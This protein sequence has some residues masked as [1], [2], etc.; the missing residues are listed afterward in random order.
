MSTT[1]ATF[2]GA[3][4]DREALAIGPRTQVRQ[5]FASILMFR[6]T[7]STPWSNVSSSSAAVTQANATNTR[8]V[9]S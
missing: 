5:K 6:S 8:R 2:W 4:L 7:T 9:L 3:L 1:L